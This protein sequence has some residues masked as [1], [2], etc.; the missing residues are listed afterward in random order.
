MSTA[1]YAEHRY[2]ERR[3]EQEP[4]DYDWLLSFADLAD[5]IR[6]FVRE[7]DALL[8]PGCGNAPF[9]PDLY[10]GGFC[11]QTAIDFSKVVIDQMRARYGRDGSVKQTL[12]DFQVMDARHLD[13]A[14]E[15]FDAVLDK[16]LIDTIICS[17]DDRTV[18]E[19]LR[20]C[21]RVLKPGGIH[22]ILSLNRKAE[23]ERQIRASHMVQHMAIF[24]IQVNNPRFMEGVPATCNFIRKFTVVVGQKHGGRPIDVEERLQKFHSPATAEELRQMQELMRTFEVDMSTVFKQLQGEH[25]E[26]AALAP[27]GSRSNDPLTNDRH[28]LQP[29]PSAAKRLLACCWCCPRRRR[30][31][32]KTDDDII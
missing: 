20:E 11:N 7:S 23:V 5:L 2:W 24:L 29:V 8:V 31:A 15:I 3:Y 21:C 19:M 17:G 27:G 6:E 12:I 14:D 16:S 30:E 26:S 10:D 28:F 9:S 18:S 32:P 4:T 13:F 22:I 1:E 25:D